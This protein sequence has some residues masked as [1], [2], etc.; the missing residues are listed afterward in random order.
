MGEIARM[1]GV[2]PQDVTVAIQGYGNVGSWAARVAAG[3][4]FRVIAVSDV[5]GGVWNPDGLEV[6]A[7]DRWVAV[8]GSVAGFEPA[9]P[10]T[11]EELLELGCDYLVP[12][13]I[14]EVIGAENAARVKARVVVEGAN[15]PVTPEGDAILRAKKVLVL[16][17]LLANAGGVTVSYFEWTQSIQQ[18]RWPLDRVLQELELRMVATFKDLMARA[19]RDGTEPRDAAFDIG[20]ERVARA[21]QL[22]GFV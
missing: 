4:G 17:D 9:E 18:F 7:L 16:P 12:A 10:I 3:M 6:A 13:A 19:G 11:N 15:H 14:G 20:L 21:I 5:K 2:A 8:A 22:R 1:E